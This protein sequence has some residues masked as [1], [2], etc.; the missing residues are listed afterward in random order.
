MCKYQP[1][2]KHKA[3]H[4]NYYKKPTKREVT[5]LMMFYRGVGDAVD[6][7]RPAMKKAGTQLKLEL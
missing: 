5:A 2:L 3:Q 6:K 7:I 4:G 1:Q